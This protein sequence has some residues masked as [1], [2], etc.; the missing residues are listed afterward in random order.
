[1]F[2]EFTDYR[3]NSTCSNPNLS[4]ESLVLKVGCHWICRCSVC[5]G[6]YQANDRLQ[7]IPACKHAFH[8]ECIDNWLSTHTT[9]PLCRLSLLASSP[10]VPQTTNDSISTNV[11]DSTEVSLQID[12]CGQSSA[13]PVTRKLQGKKFSIY[14]ANWLLHVW[15]KLFLWI[16]IWV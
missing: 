15:L 12:H 7:Q 10:T 4:Y 13:D 16:V 6:D 8:M 5:L 11:E 9:C 2:L 14:P 3:N 1:M